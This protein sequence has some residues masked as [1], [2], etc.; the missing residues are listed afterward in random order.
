MVEQSREAWLRPRLAALRDRPR[1]VPR[2]ARAVDLIS[3]V[4]PVGEIDT[5]AQREVAAAAA[6]TAI[7]AEIEQRWPGAPYVIGQGGSEEY[8][9]LELAPETEALVVIGVVYEVI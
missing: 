5:P 1:L 6:R 9:D 3:R 8:A 7:A 2:Q 4:L